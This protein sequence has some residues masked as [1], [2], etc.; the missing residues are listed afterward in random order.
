MN[1]YCQYNHRKDICFPDFNNDDREFVRGTDNI[2]I[3][4]PK[5]II[6]GNRNVPRA[7]LTDIG[8]T[9]AG[10]NNNIGYFSSHQATA[11]PIQ[12]STDDTQISD[13]LAS[14][15]RTKTYTTSPEITM[16]SDKRHAMQ[17]L[18]KTISL[19]DNR[20]QLGLLR[21]PNANLPNNYKAAIFQYH[22]MK[23]QLKKNSEKLASTR[24]QLTRISASIT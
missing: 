5:T 13:L 9:I 24:I 18:W 6:K 7:V 14:F 12:I 19:Y 10:P 16:S 17:T 3:I 21:K 11:T 20:Y 1:I 4:S 22:W 23:I 15:W 8:W 2:D